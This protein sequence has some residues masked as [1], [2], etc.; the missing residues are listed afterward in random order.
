MA[1]VNARDGRAG[2][3]RI[4]LVVGGTTAG[5]F[6]TE[7]LLARLHAEPDCREALADMLSHPL[8]STGDRLNETLGPFARIRTVSSACSSGANAIAIGAAWLL[9]GEVDVVVAGGSDGLCRLT[10]SGFNALAALDPAPCRPFH[11]NRRGTSLGEGAGFLVLERAERAMARGAKPVAALAGWALGAEAHHITQPAGDGS[12]VAALIESAMTDAGVAP[13]DLD[14]VN[15]HG[16]GTPVNDPVEAAALR[17][18]SWQGD[19]TRARVELQGADRTRPGRC[20]RDRGGDHGA[21]RLAGRARSDGRPRRAGSGGGRRPR[22]G[23]RPGG[24]T[25]ARGALE[26]VRIRRH[27]HRPRV[28]RGRPGRPRAARSPV[29]GAPARSG[30]H[31][32]RGV[33][34]M[35][36]AR[37]ER[38]RRHPGPRLLPRHPGRS[39]RAPRPRAQPPLRRGRAPRD[40]RRRARAPRVGCAARRG[41][42]GAWERLR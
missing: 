6:E 32:G 7:R 1:G 22:S 33:R 42:R 38:L 26:R 29:P 21:R 36:A 40:R 15:S 34:A 19:R 41:R 4:G 14:Y 23:G 24:R 30:R 9:L 27:G 35:R 20:R 37:S 18:G 11:S 8:S 13:A 25:R 28:H 31:R 2:S 3:A 16:T 17:E 5:M 10:L 39:R 12:V